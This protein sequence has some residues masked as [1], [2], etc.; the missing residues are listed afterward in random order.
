MY[1]I[2][3][4]FRRFCFDRAVLTFGAALEAALDSVEAK[5]DKQREVKRA[6]TLDRWLGRELKF[7]NPIATK[8]KTTEPGP[9]TEIDQEYQMRGDGSE[10]RTT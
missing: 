8:S 9:T 5:N 4:D 10:G 7:R 3:G 1:A 6:R 2:Q